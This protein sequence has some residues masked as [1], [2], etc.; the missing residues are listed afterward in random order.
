MCNVYIEYNIYNKIWVKI[1]I[2]N[3]IFKIIIYNVFTFSSESWFCVK[4]WVLRFGNSYLG[5]R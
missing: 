1:N 2:F 5:L 4:Y 3:I